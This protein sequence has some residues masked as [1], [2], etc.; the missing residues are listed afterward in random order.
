[1]AKRTVPEETEAQWKSGLKALDEAVKAL[2]GQ[3]AVA[4]IV[5]AKQPSVYHAL[6]ES[7][8]VP[9]EWC[10]PIERAMEEKRALDEN[11]KV[12]TRRDLRPDLWPEE[13]APPQGATSEIRDTA[14]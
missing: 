9:A 11:V 12:I 2:G 10:L 6:T 3:Q 14:A 8:K 5:G 7:K 1:M 4:E 13:D